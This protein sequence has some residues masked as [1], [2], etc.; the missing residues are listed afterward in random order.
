MPR[1]GSP[2]R[3]AADRAGGGGVGDVDQRAAGLDEEVELLVGARL[4]SLGAAPVT[5]VWTPAT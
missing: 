4:V 1:P 5:D 3:R 2:S